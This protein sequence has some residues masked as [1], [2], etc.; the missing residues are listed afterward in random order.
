MNLLHF[1]IFLKETNK[2]NNYI[3]IISYKNLI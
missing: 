1:L 3:Y 2:N